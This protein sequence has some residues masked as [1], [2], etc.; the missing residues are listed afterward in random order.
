MY[1]PKFTLKN[2]ILYQVRY[3]AKN[4]RCDSPFTSQFA[5]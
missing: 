5:Q 4:E 2:S 1:S 3:P